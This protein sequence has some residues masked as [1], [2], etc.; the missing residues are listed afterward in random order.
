MNIGSD[1][2]YYVIDV[3]IL[4]SQSL[5]GVELGRFCYAC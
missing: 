3:D 2:Q 4:D 1:I 5:I